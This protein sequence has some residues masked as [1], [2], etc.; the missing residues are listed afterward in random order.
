MFEFFKKK[1]FKF[2][3][4]TN[5]SHLH[6][7][8]KIK[9]IGY[10]GCSTVDL[11]MCKECMGCNKLF[12]IKQIRYNQK[13]VNYSYNIFKEKAN[14][15]IKKEYIINRILKHPNI[16]NI[17][18]YDIDNLCLTF[19][20]DYSIDLLD[21]FIN[22]QPNNMKKHF[23]YYIQIIDAVKY[24]HSLGI[25][26]MDLKLENILINKLENKIQLIDFGHSC[27]FKK[28]NTTIYNRG[29]KGTEYYMSPEMWYGTY[30]SDK[31]DVWAC[32]IVLYNFIYNKLP[33]GKAIE[34]RDEI[35]TVFKKERLKNSLC[36][37]IF[38]HPTLYGFSYDDS[39]IILDLFLKMLNISYYDRCGIDI[40]YKNLLKITLE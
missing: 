10:G 27:F 40:I 17:Q 4:S 35:Y 33:W 15:A 14:E 24:M 25:A 6:S 26:H 3:F 20:Y 5:K 21:F 28:G 13:L 2:I 23:K 37:G 22:E 29:I 34:D 30:M 9:N 31:V 32:G 11:Y 18:G 39:Y 38:E 7:A 12:V 19:K 16:I 1:S 8:K 36:Q